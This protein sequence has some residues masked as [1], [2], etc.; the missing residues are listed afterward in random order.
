MGQNDLSMIVHVCGIDQVNSNEKIAQVNLIESVF[1]EKNEEENT[2]N[3][4]VRTSKKPEWK[5]FIYKEQGN[6][7]KIKDVIKENIKKAKANKDD[8]KWK[9]YKN[10]TIIC[11]ADNDNDKLLLKEFNA[12]HK[13]LN[14]YFPLILFIF[15]NTNK[16][17][18]DY[19]DIFFDVTYLKCINLSDIPK[20]NIDNEKIQKLKILYLLTILKNRYH[21]Y[22]TECGYKII[23]EID[24]LTNLST[25]GIYL[26][27]LLIGN[28]GCGKTTF[29][30]VVAGE[31]IAK[32]SSSVEPV[33]SKVAYYD[34][35][36]KGIND[37]RLEINNNQ[38]KNDAYIRF[39]DT[40]GF[41]QKKDIETIYKEIN[42]IFYSYEEGKERIPII[43]YFLQSGRSFG[44]EPEKREKTLKILRL[45]KEKCGKIIFIVTRSNE[46]EWE[47]S[48]AF[49]DFLEENGLES[50]LEENLSNIIT[51]NLAG[52][53]PRGIKKI[54]GKLYSLLNI[55][56]SNEIFNQAL[57]NGI[58]A[59]PN[60]ELKLKYLKER[61]NLFDLYKTKEDIIKN[62]E[63]K[64]GALISSLSLTGGY[65][66]LIPIPF[67]DVGIVVS[68]IGTMIVKIASFYGYAWDTIIEEDVISILNGN[69]YIKREQDNE[70]Q[71]RNDNNSNKILNKVIIIN[72]IKG[73]MMGSFLTATA[74]ILDD[75]IKCIPIIGP[76]LG[77][78]VGAVVDF[79][80]IVILGERA[81]NYF[82]SKCETEDGTSFF[83]K[84]CNEYEIIFNK[85][86][87][88]Q[89][90][91]VIYP[92]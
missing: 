8:K 85:F 24:P 55:K 38:L 73:L 84:R 92:K 26:P 5:A 15:K 89:N 25:R 68:L 82:K 87:E 78:I 88:F 72:V 51:C 66:G 30:N 4:N 17:I 33:T 20:N 48:A 14:Q 44:S 57:I 22:Y 31:R 19:K 54:V 1:T 46:D 40:P 41:D 76:V 59:R 12:I 58:I 53:Y 39:I 9:A 16:S 52:K 81:N 43:L 69:N 21:N 60:F 70:V 80:M 47:Q 62:A 49:Q 67:V 50:L 29:I 77:S 63:F 71:H 74:L 28:P 2:S 45:L 90:C 86:K 34:I 32:A 3:Y 83:C 13:E 91:D 36:L 56:D 11:F 18:K 65:S 75:G 42:S 61:T 10:N 35:K 79:G 23:D 7:L 27:M 6:I 37:N 64:S